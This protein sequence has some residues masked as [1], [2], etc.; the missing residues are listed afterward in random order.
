ML[1]FAN[2]AGTSGAGTVII[3]ALYFF[4]FNYKSSIIL[5]LASVA[6]SSVVRYIQNFNKP[7]PLKK[8]KGVLIDYAVPTIMMP[9]IVIG[10]SLGVI[11]N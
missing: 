1:I 7:H 3:I 9:S 2:C 11:V 5:S 6:T 10:V 4:G 8:G